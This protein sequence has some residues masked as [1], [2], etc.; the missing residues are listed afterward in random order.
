MRSQAEADDFMFTYSEIYL[1]GD[2]LSSTGIGFILF[3]FAYV[4]RLLIKPPLSNNF[5]LS[6]LYSPFTPTFPPSSSA[7]QHRLKVWACCS[8][9]IEAFGIVYC[10][11][12]I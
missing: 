3:H 4:A 10:T 6:P 7:P 9:I 8:L 11:G 5:F 2:L 12:L 1:A